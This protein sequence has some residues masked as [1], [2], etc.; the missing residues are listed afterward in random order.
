MVQIASE[1]VLPSNSLI[2]REFEDDVFRSRMPDGSGGGYRLSI[3]RTGSGLPQDEVVKQ[4]P[5]AA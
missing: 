3:R 1:I 2:Q 4:H 5:A